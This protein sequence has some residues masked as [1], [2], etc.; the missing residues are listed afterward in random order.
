VLSRPDIAAAEA[1]VRQADAQVTLQRRQRVPDVTASVQFERNPIGQPDTVGFG[2][3]LPLPFWNHYDGEIG[4]ARAART[5][6]EAQLDKTRIAATAGVESARLSF[7]E[8]YARAKRYESSLAPKS[9]AVTKSVAYSYEKGGASLVLLLE[10]ERDDNQIRVG[11]VQA[12][13][14]AASAAVALQA[15]LGRL[16]A[17]PSP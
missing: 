4:A 13:A 15:A 8:A 17:T 2:L 9:A 10:A 5:Q 3:S 14:D 12:Q 1:A 6:A 16:E 7:L 11:A